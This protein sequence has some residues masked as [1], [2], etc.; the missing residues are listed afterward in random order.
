MVSLEGLADQ[1][2]LSKELRRR[3]RNNGSIF[4]TRGEGKVPTINIKDACFNAHALQPA[5]RL[6]AS[7]PRDEFGA[8]KL[9]T[10]AAAENELPACVWKLEHFSPYFQSMTLIN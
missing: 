8:V 3:I 6:M 7:A 2:D 9:F 1:W 10:I 4:L 5:L